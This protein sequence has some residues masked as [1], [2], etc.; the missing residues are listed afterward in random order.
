MWDGQG[1]EAKEE[2]ALCICIVIHTVAQQKLT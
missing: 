1:G 2:G